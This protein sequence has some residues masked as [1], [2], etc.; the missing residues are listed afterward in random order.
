ME[1][2]VVAEYNDIAIDEVEDF[3]DEEHA[4][5]PPMAYK[6]RRGGVD[7]LKSRPFQLIVV[8][9]CILIVI[10]FLVVMFL[11]INMNRTHFSSEGI[12]YFSVTYIRDRKQARGEKGA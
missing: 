6:H 3:E 2:E 7:R 11:A 8:A 9:A 4:H 1:E 5:A 12:H 10:S